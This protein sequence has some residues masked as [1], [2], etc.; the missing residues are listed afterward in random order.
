MFAV[1]DATPEDA[2]TIATMTAKMRFGTFTSGYSVPDTLGIIT[3]GRSMVAVAD[4]SIIGYILVT[5]D[6]HIMSLWVESAWRRRGVAKRLIADS[7][8]SSL[9]TAMDNRAALAL[10]TRLGFRVTSILSDYYGKGFTA[11]HM[12]L[13]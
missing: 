10:Y 9:N 3:E 8:G 5:S 13:E 7:G 2:G 6:S 12:E 1:R 11:L 4:G